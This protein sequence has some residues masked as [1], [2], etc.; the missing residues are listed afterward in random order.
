MPAWL[1]GKPLRLAA[2]AAICLFMFLAG[3]RVSARGAAPSKATQEDLSKAMH[4]EAFAYAQY[5]LFADHAR[6]Q[7]DTE[8]AALFE[9]TAKT[10]RFEHFAEEARLAG[11]VGSDAENLRKAIA[12]ES[13]EAA[14]MYP[15]FARAA[16]AHGDSAA[17]ERF[18]EIGQDEAKHRDAFRAALARLEKK[19]AAR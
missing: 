19:T 13:Y 16:R 12:G 18:T 15:G 7:G 10:E 9:N 3:E 6:R 1:Q 11:L 2:A 17:A 8:L 14:T 4:G 5:L